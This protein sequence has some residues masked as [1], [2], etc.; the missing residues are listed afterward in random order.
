MVNVLVLD[1]K[2]DND[3]V[4]F[5]SSVTSFCNLG[6]KSVAVSVPKCT[7]CIFLFT[8]CVPLLRL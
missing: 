1:L 4:F 8:R 6:S 5:I 2:T 3:K 7:V